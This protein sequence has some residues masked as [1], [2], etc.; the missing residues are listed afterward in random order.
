MISAGAEFWAYCIA[1]SIPYIQFVSSKH[2]SS[3]KITSHY[4]LR[5]S[6]SLGLAVFVLSGLA[7]RAGTVESYVVVHLLHL[8]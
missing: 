2:F 1:T 5:S 4:V 7:P 8:L 6:L 3:P